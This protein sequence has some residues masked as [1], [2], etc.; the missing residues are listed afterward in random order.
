[1]YTMYLDDRSHPIWL[2]AANDWRYVV[3]EPRL[4]QELNR[5]D[6]LTFKLPPVNAQYNS[7]NLLTSSVILCDDV[8]PVFFGRVL[9]VKAGMYGEK[10]VTCEGALAF[11]NDSVVELPYSFSGGDLDFAAAMVTV[12]NDQASANRQLGCTLSGGTAQL[13][14]KPDDYETCLDLL[15]EHWEHP[16]TAAYD[17]IKAY[18]TTT[19]T[20]TNGV[21]GAKLDLV[22]ITDALSG[23]QPVELGLNLLDIT[24][25][26]S[27]ED[28]FTVCVPLGADVE[29]GEYDDDGNEIKRP[30]TVYRLPAITDDPTAYHAADSIFVSNQTGIAN[31]GKIVRTVANRDIGPD[32]ETTYAQAR[33]ALYDA[34]KEALTDGILAAQTIEATA[35]DL[36]LAGM[37]YQ[38]L[39]LGYP[40]RVRHR[41]LGI[42]TV[43]QCTRVNLDLA[44]PEKS[45]YT[46]GAERSTLTNQ[47]VQDGRTANAALSTAQT[48]GGTSSGSIVITA[49]PVSV[50]VA[51]GATASFTV[52]AT[53]DG[54]SYQW[55]ELPAGNG[56]AWT[57]VSGE[58]NASLSF[59]AAAAR[60]GSKFRCVLKDS[61]G[62]SKATTATAK[63]T[64]T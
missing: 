37:Y 62:A 23:D 31:Y 11:L 17:N 43:L 45:K 7:I 41:L 4:K 48:S 56:S 35:V 40:V 5:A 39:R 63:L 60:N 21:F 16:I 57:P 14:V 10:L 42:D 33:L 6:V 34:A 46:F 44:D 22:A 50:S 28:V 13:E 25:D 1:M 24:D 12:H 58:T 27:G 59:T 38:G 29:T 2:P 36:K 47:T 51:A 20:E 54:L 30:L 19:V 32:D 55:Q 53:G 18:L 26:V 61:S 8:G 64:V 52:S 15:M 9:S 49:Q 3:S